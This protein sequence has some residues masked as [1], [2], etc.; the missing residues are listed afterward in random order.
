MS[1]KALGTIFLVIGLFIA[2]FLIVFLGMSAAV[3]QNGARD[4]CI[5]HG[6]NDAEYAFD[7]WYCKDGLEKPISVF[8]LKVIDYLEENN[9]SN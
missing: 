3:D 2:V 7:E 1:D 9:I 6:Y 8:K 5:A 4:F